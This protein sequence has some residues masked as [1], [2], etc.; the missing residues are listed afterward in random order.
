MALDFGAILGKGKAPPMPSAA[1]DPA[2]EE[3]GL[4]VRVMPIAQDLLE[5]VR[6]GDA[7]AVADALIAAQKA[8]SSGASDGPEPGPEPG[9][10]P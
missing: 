3:D 4:K 10:E 6:G 2:D 1:P 7:D 8:I 5:A 9:A